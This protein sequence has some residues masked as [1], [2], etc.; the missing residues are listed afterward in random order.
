[1]KPSQF[2][3]ALWGPTPPGRIQLWRL[4]DKKAFYPVSNAAADYYIGADDM[5]TCVALTFPKRAVTAAGR[6]EAKHAI[7]L[8]GMWIDIDVIGGPD[9]KKKGAATKAEAIAVTSAV[10]EPT[11]VVDSGYGIHAWH[12]FDKPWLFKTADDQAAGAALAWQWQQTHR[13]TTGVHMD[14][15]HDV[16]RLMRLPGTINCKGDARAPVEALATDGQKHVLDDIRATAAAAGPASLASPQP[17]SGD[18]HVNV[19]GNLPPGTLDALLD[20]P[21]FHATWTHSRPTADG[22]TSAYD[23][24]IASQL[25]HAGCW[26]DQQ[27]ADV[28]AEHRLS[29]D[30]TDRK[31]QRIGYLKKTIA[32]ARAGHDTET[33]RDTLRTLRDDARKA[34]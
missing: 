19:P 24:S 9:N 17:G 26:T 10:L 7:A 27:I 25:H 4:S 18:I 12:L 14:S 32:R 2:L 1:M 31:H 3:D 21:D 23:L 8:A 34:A 13:L 33:P 22:S 28:I 20:D 16:A 15:V 5:F 6:P 29:R 11:I 30:P